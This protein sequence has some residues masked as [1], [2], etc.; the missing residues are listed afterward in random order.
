VKLAPLTL[1]FVCAAPAFADVAV[2][3]AKTWRDGCAAR[4]DEA[5]KA[6]A[7]QPG[8]RASVIPLLHENGSKNPVEYVE[9]AKDGY[10]LTVGDEPE[11]RPDQPWMMFKRADGPPYHGPMLWRRYHNRFARS[12][13]QHLPQPF[14]D[15]LDDCLKMGEAK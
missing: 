10:Q 13:R 6:L 1:L 3:Q 4:I 7:L 14:M 9:Y 2:P 12:N 15:A 5:A 11:P 8:A